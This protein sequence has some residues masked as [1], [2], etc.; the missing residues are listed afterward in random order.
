M[1]SPSCQPLL[2]AGPKGAL[3]QCRNQGC[4]T[5][6]HKLRF[7]GANVIKME[8]RTSLV[9]GAPQHGTSPASPQTEL[10]GSVRLAPERRS[11][12]LVSSST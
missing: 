10:W 7:H 9:S 4:L 5:A 6:T 12:W 1:G 3:F 2:R 11:S 8:P